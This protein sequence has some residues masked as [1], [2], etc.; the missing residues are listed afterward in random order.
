[1]ADIS[2]HQAQNI[3][4]SQDYMEGQAGPFWVTRFYVHSKD[5][6]DTLTV[7][8]DGPVQPTIPDPE[9]RFLED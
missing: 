1:M 5:G 7:F 2:I 8:T 3:R 6:V 9:P 4:I